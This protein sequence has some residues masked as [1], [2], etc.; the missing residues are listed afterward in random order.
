MK[1]DMVTLQRVDEKSGLLITYT[2]TRKEW[3][4]LSVKRLVEMAKHRRAEK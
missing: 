3:L 1:E 4:D 2:M